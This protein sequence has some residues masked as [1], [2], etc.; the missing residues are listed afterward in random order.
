MDIEYLTRRLQTF[1]DK[2]NW[3]KYHTPKNLAMALAGEAGE[4]LELFQWLTEDESLDDNL[5]PKTR[6][7]V[8]EEL[9]DICLYLIRLSDKLNIDLE[10]A[11]H[12]KILVNEAKYP[13]NLSKDN[14]TKYN[15]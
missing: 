7:R 5:Q 3:D 4:L 8:K 2:R 14:A 12:D 15:R 6:E 13:V 9:A 1:A 10:R 11:C